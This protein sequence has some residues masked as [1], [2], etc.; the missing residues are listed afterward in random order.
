MVPLFMAE[1]NKC[2]RFH[3][4]KSTCSATKDIPSHLC[5]PKIHHHLQKSLPL[6][7]ILVEINTFEVKIN[8]RFYWQ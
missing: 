4:E 2:V 7:Y 8:V 6:V 5:Q 1:L 3:T